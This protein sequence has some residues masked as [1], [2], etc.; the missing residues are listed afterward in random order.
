MAPRSLSPIMT[1]AGALSAPAIAFGLDVEL[2]RT[3][4][5]IEIDGRLDDEAWSDAVRIEIDIETRPG[6]NIPARVRT[7]AYLVEDGTNLYVGFDAE[8]PDPSAIRAFLRDRDS[9]WDDDFVG[10]AVD[11]YGDARS[12]FLRIRSVSRWT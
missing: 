11:T 4:R 5:S 1:L 3:D 2:P 10:I 7:V 6:E 12:S 8:D 9:A